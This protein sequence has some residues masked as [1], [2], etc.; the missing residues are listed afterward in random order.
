MLYGSLA[1]W[2]AQEV[3]VINSRSG[4]G[5]ITALPGWP[6]EIKGL[7]ISLAIFAVVALAYPYIAGVSLK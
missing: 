4:E 3:I 1:L 2:A 5:E 7:L 6:E